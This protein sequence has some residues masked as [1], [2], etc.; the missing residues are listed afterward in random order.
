MAIITISRQIAS[1]G[2]ETSAAA[3]KLLGY[4]FIDRKM[5][6]E[7]L[8]KK[9]ISRSNLK[10]YDERKPGFLASLSK[11]RDEYFD[12]LRE[13]VYEYASEDNAIFIGRGGFAILKDIPGVYAVRLIAPDK[14]RVLRLME[15]FDYSEKQAQELMH[16][17]D[18]NRGGFHKCF[19]NVEHDDSIFYDMVLNTGK[20]NADTAAQIIKFGLTNTITEQDS[21]AGKKRI[22]NLLQG[23]KIVNRI[24]FDLKMQVYFLDAEVSDNEIVL[25][26][27][28]ESASIVEKVLSTAS[29]MAEG[30]TIS[31]GINIVNDYKPFP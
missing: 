4:R 1:F 17:S 7:Y 18:N 25:H 24:S 2:D 20:I 8:L 23:Q 3:A 28:A 16:E 12:Y 11:N 19:F 15:E 14:T 26:G 22:L 10:K 29:E 31:S 6:E 21:A 30:K 13:A 5:L 9:G 27:I